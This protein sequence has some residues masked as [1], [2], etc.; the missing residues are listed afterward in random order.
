MGFA[1]IG[2]RRMLGVSRTVGVVRAAT[3]GSLPGWN[4]PFWDC[5]G[6]RNVT[7]RLVG[8]PSPSGVSGTAAGRGRPPDQ[9]T[10]ARRA[11]AQ[12]PAPDP[13]ERDAGGIGAGSPLPA[14]LQDTDGSPTEAGFALIIGLALPRAA[15]DKPN[16][17]GSGAETGRTLPRK[18]RQLVTAV[19]VKSLALSPAPQSHLKPARLRMPRPKVAG[20]GQGGRTAGARPGR[21]R[22]TGAQPGRPRKRARGLGWPR[23][24]DGGR[25]GLGGP[26]LGGP[27]RRAPVR[28][29]RTAGA[30]TVGAWLGR[31]VWCGAGLGGPGRRRSGRAGR[32]RTAWEDPGRLCRRC[33]MA[34]PDYAIGGTRGSSDWRC[35]TPPL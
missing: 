34:V 15:Q 8:F 33:G 16:C 17:R 12:T 14:R 10:P 19:P 21:P 20:A 32:G 27:G 29:G 30:R 1:R 18:P 4:R 24:P 2:V 9:R 3:V 13:R 7:G 11:P 28:E 5:S 35:R 22:I 6:K 31:A 25:P 26:G 23:M